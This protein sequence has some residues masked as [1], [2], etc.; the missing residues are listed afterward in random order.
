[1]VYLFGRLP[2]CCIRGM[3]I[4]ER[5]WLRRWCRTCP[6]LQDQGLVRYSCSMKL[7]HCCCEMQLSVT[8]I[9]VTC[10][11][12]EVGATALMHKH[13]LQLPGKLQSLDRVRR[14][15]QRCGM[16]ACEKQACEKQATYAAVAL[17]KSST[18]NTVESKQH[19][20]QWPCRTQAT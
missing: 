2:R 18:M 11:K 1:M 19:T 12:A 9:A 6:L 5:I 20:Q 17:Q 13:K 10:L 15:A 3:L 4:L 14:T 16:Q 7:A 8:L